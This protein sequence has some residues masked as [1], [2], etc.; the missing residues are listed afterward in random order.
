[1]RQSAQVRLTYR[2]RGAPPARLACL[3]D[4][5]GAF[6]EESS[7][8]DPLPGNEAYA[9]GLGHAEV[10][11]D[12]SVLDPAELAIATE[13]NQAYVA[14]ALPGL[15]SEP[16]EARHCWITTLPWSPDGFAVWEAGAALFLAGDRMFKHAPV[17]GR[18]LAEAALDGHLRPEL[19][20]E[21][22]LGAVEANV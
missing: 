7:Y 16:F 18:T 3:L 22:Q 2:V 5:G 4:A 8:A 12:G 14:R 19:R 6:G 17:I 10:G 21:A 20:P 13:R 15:D 9:V 11:R 1:V